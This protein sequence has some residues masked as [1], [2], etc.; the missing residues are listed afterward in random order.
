M[1]PLKITWFDAG[2]KPQGQADPA[3]PEGVDVDLSLGRS[4]ACSAALPYPALRCG[5]F[6]IQCSACGYQ[7]A[8]TTAGRPD[9]P[10]SVKIACA[11]WA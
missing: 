6:E 9:D 10:R 7:G 11:K 1:K 4:P 8:V 3:F 5:W 2:R